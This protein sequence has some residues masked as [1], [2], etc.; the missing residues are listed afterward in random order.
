[1]TKPAVYNAFLNQIGAHGQG[2]TALFLPVENGILFTVQD[3]VSQRRK[4]APYYYASL[5]DESGKRRCR[6]MLGTDKEYA[7]ALQKGSTLTSSDWVSPLKGNPPWDISL[8]GSREVYRS[9][10]EYISVK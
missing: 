3:V 1:M 10:A 9:A 7:E 5:L 6:L 2:R 8:K 4:G